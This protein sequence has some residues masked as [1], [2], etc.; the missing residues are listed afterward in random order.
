LLICGNDE[1]AAAYLLKTL[2]H[3][4]QKPGLKQ[5]ILIT[6]RGPQGS[7]KDL[8]LDFTGAVLGAGMYLNT[9]R[10]KDILGDFNA[11]LEGK[12]LVKLEEA[13]L[14][15]TGGKN[16]EKIKSLATAATLQ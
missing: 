6:L 3:Q 16:A 5:P 2:A 7:G 8:L 13:N 15:A 12:L 4:V 11:L 14:G 1:A 9:S 10:G